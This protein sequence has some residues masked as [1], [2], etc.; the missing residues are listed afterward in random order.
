MTTILRLILP[1]ISERKK[2]V[3]TN[4]NEPP[5]TI[6]NKPCFGSYCMR[7]TVYRN[8]KDDE[9]MYIYNGYSDDF[10]IAN[11]TE[12]VCQRECQSTEYCSNSTL[13]FMRD[14]P[15][16]NGLITETNIN[17][18]AVRIVKFGK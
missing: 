4:S 15:N 14:I 6:D 16:C 8:N 1:N 10:E 17:N 3:K 5:K 7:A 2:Q 12:N 13:M 11:E 9:R 18:D